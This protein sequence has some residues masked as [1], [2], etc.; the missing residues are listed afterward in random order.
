MIRQVFKNYYEQLHPLTLHIYFICVLILSMKLTHPIFLI[1]NLII[2][3][4]YL[5]TNIGLKLYFRKLIYIVPMT[6]LIMI[7]NPLFNH[8][9]ATPILYINDM[10]ITIESIVSS[11]FVGILIISLLLWFSA[12]GSCIDSY[13]F[14]YIFGRIMPTVSLM[15]TMIIRFIPYFS[16]KLEQIKQ[17][18]LTF[19]YSTSDGP[20]KKRLLSGS[21]LLTILIS[22][23][24]ENSIDTADSMQSRGYGLKP[25]GHYAHYKYTVIDIMISCLSITAF[26]LLMI[27]SFSNHYVFHYYP[28]F[29]GLQLSSQLYLPIIGYSILLI[30][31]ILYNITEAIKWH[32]LT[33]KI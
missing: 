15:I 30:S 3:S 25:R 16:Y 24:L 12:L 29:T 9:G 23:S 31:P 17:T 10:P 20:M 4:I 14:L 11:I 13:K 27:F 18:Q 28:N 2:G 6:L 33:S 1:I 22:T 5:I 19:G 7:I 26:V 8:R 21:K 32:I